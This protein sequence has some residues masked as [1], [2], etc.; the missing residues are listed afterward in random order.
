MNE[1]VSAGT[2]EFLRVDKQWAGPGSSKLHWMPTRRV[3]YSPYTPYARQNKLDT[4]QVVEQGLQQSWIEDDGR[5]NCRV[6]RDQW[7]LYQ[8]LPVI[9]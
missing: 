3:R 5:D 2:P 9:R 8:Q 1:A 6:T 4:F 7:P